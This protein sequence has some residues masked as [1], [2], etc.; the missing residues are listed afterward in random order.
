MNGGTSCCY[1]G[2][3]NIACEVA[4][5]G[6]IRCVDVIEVDELDLRRSDRG[7]LKSDLTSDGADA[8]NGAGDVVESRR[9]NQVLLAGESVVRHAG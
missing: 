2:R 8:D 7:E 3:A 5:R 6:D 9:G 4:L 1:L